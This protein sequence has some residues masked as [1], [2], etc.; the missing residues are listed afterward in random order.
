[1]KEIQHKLIKASN[2]LL[3]DYP[4]YAHLL[5]RIKPYHDPEF[6]FPLAIKQEGKHY[7]L[8]YNFEK[9]PTVD[10]LV[11]GL[12]HELEHIIR[13]SH[14]RVYGRSSDILA[15]MIASDIE[16]NGYEDE[17][18]IFPLPGDIT[19]EI[20]T[21]IR[22]PKY[23][24]TI[25]A[26]LEFKGKLLQERVYTQ[27]WTCPTCTNVHFKRLHSSDSLQP[28]LNFPSP[29]KCTRC[30]AGII[31][32]F[33]NKILKAASI[34]KGYANLKKALKFGIKPAANDIVADTITKPK[35][36]KSPDDILEWIT[37]YLTMPTKI[38]FKRLNKRYTSDLILPTYES[39]FAEK[40][41]LCLDVSLSMDADTIASFIDIMYHLNA[42]YYFDYLTFGD[43][44]FVPPT[45]ITSELHVVRQGGT[46]YEMLA[47][48]L[49]KLKSKYEFI[50][51][52]TDGQ[53]GSIDSFNKNINLLWIIANGNTFSSK[54][55]DT[56]N[57]DFN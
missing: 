21:P 7:I 20:G 37:S 10:E 55:H 14:A 3:K 31:P 50:I 46:S 23:Y 33:K 19:T 22:L 51:I 52:L 38:T 36:Q 1:M 44:I 43:K 18:Y 40:G 9:I 4:Q 26:A 27:L 30:G 24:R 39:T 6:L 29:A 17:P 45:P 13:A 57:I 47:Q 54:K 49:N 32:Q 53:G 35:Y 11:G 2:K 34:R 28:V 8:F 15:S 42:T 12:C 5:S 25:Y 41:L 16:I 56:Y 48:Y